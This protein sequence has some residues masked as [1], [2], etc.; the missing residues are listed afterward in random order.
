MLEAREYSLDTTPPQDYEPEARLWSAMSLTEIADEYRTDKG[1]IKHNYTQV[2]EKYLSPLRIDPYQHPAYEPLALLEIGVACGAS[3]KM[4][5]RYM[6]HAQITGVDINPDCAKLCQDYNNIRIVI[7]DATKEQ[8]PGTFDVII[9][10]GSHTARDMAAT[11]KLHWNSLKTG[12]Y[13]ILEDTGCT[14]PGRKYHRPTRLE[15]QDER[16]YYLQ[17]LD[18]FLKAVDSGGDVEFVHCHRQC[19]IIRKK[20]LNHG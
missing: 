3:L 14:L 5:S 9:D 2:Y 20:E 1:T 19:V 17:V 10:D 7:A 6:P 12:G 18:G 13:Y 4:W 8:I 11:C 16:L 15:G